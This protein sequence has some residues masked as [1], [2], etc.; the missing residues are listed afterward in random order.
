MEIPFI[1]IHECLISNLLNR[2]ML[3]LIVRIIISR[4][5][6]LPTSFNS[7]INITSSYFKALMV[8]KVEGFSF[9]FP[10]EMQERRKQL[11]RTISEVL[12]TFARQSVN[13]IP[14]EEHCV[15]CL[16]NVYISSFPNS[17]LSERIVFLPPCLWSF[18]AFC[19][20][21]PTVC[22]SRI[23]TLNTG[24]RRWV[25]PNRLS[26]LGVKVRTTIGI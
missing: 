11:W 1:F 10:E 14:L 9:V 20:H 2:Q 7:T 8:I 18:T 23:L 5:T 24:P 22:T 3:S 16:Q 25:K 13:F 15:T 26:W 6:T 19:M 12:S 17:G 21:R 4:M